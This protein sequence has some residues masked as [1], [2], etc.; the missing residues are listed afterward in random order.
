MSEQQN[1]RTNGIYHDDLQDLRRELAA[2]RSET[3]IFHAGLKASL[4]GIARSNELLEKAV[5]HLSSTIIAGRR[6][7]P[8]E[9][10]GWV[11]LVVFLL[12]A[13]VGAL[14]AFVPFL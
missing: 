13:G 7:V 11:F 6:S 9:I 5:L 1:H 2:E 14:K 4:D 10:F 12:I 8:I 3:R